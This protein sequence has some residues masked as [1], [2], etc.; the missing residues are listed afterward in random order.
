[1]GRCCPE[2][3]INTSEDLFG[4]M[5]FLVNSEGFVINVGEAQTW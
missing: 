4:F 5:R 2:E 3:K 1:M